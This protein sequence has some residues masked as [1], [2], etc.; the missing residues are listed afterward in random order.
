[1]GYKMIQ[2]AK[3]MSMELVEVLAI[4]TVFL[5]LT[6]YTIAADGDPCAPEES[7]DTQKIKSLAADVSTAVGNNFAK[8]G[9]KGAGETS[10]YQ[11]DLTHLQGIQFKISSFDFNFTN[12]SD[13]HKFSSSC[14]EMQFEDAVP[15]DYK[16]FKLEELIGGA[17]INTNDGGTPIIGG[18]RATVF[19]PIYCA[20]KDFDFVGIDILNREDLQKGT[21]N[22]VLADHITLS[23]GIQTTKEFEVPMNC[24]DASDDKVYRVTCKPAV[25]SVTASVRKDKFSPYH[26]EDFSVLGLFV[27]EAKKINTPTPPEFISPSIDGTIPNGTAPDGKT[28]Y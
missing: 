1:M 22:I 24:Q 7:P 11:K 23:H 12:K 15:E 13:G 10:S 16:E 6:P 19:N 8:A 3:R 28:R 20:G 21:I 26:K 5:M 2:N 25:E 14:N 18:P 4:S 27:L 17:R 9:K